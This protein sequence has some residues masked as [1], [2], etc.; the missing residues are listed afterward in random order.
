LVG[1]AAVVGGAV[2]QLEQPDLLWGS[3]AADT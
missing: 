2:Q 1:A 3:V